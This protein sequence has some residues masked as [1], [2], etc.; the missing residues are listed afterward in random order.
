MLLFLPTDG[1]SVDSHL[2]A[3]PNMKILAL[4]PL[5]RS[6][7]DLCMCSGTGCRLDMS[8]A[9]I[10]ILI[11]P[12]KGKILFCQYPAIDPI[13][14]PKIQEVAA[15]SQTI[16]PSVCFQEGLCNMPRTSKPSWPNLAPYISFKY[17]DE[18]KYHHH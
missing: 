1:D 7:L 11:L 2:H 18:S 13:V 12:W 8:G 3:H 16:L 4:Y 5:R 6:L 10:H 15:A 17:Q 9:P 14:I